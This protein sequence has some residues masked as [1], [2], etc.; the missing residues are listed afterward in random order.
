MS[1]IISPVVVRGVEAAP[2]GTPY[3]CDD[4]GEQ[5]LWAYLVGLLGLQ[6]ICTECMTRWF[7]IVNA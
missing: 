1:G 2:E 3:R 5:V 6:H 4:C 7:E